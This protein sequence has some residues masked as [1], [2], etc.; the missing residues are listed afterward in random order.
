MNDSIKIWDEILQ[1]LTSKGSI[2]VQQHR[3]GLLAFSVSPANNL[4]C[5]NICRKL[6]EQLLTVSQPYDLLQVKANIFSP[7]E[8]FSAHLT[9]HNRVNSF[10]VAEQYNGLIILSIW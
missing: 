2:T 7:V 4:D 6:N 10:Q 8:L 1:K 5:N 3:H 9:L